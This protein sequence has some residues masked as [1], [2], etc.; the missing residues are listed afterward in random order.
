[1]LIVS[2]AA[3]A[4]AGIAISA[5]IA[6]IISGTRE[7]AAFERGAAQNA[8]QLGIFQEKQSA[9]ANRIQ[10][11][12]AR[13]AS[14]DA[15]IEQERKKTSTLNSQVAALE[16]S[17]QR[18]PQLEKELAAS[19]QELSQKHSEIAR[20]ET[21]VDKERR[22]TEE[23]LA[24]LSEA[25]DQ[26]KTDFQNLANRILEE[27]SAKF[28][29]QNK[30]NLDMVLNPLRDQIGD[31]RKRVDDVYAN[32]SKDRQSLAEKIKTLSDLN[33][34]V[35]K[36]ADNLSKALRGGSGNK[37][38]GN[39]GEMILVRALELSGLKKGIE[40]DTQVS[41]ESAEGEKQIPDV[42]VHLPE[43]RDVVVDSKVTL[44][45]YRK[46]VS[47]ETD[48]E[49]EIALVQNDESVRNHIDLLSAKAYELHSKVKSLDFVL[50]FMPIE[51][52][53]VSA[54]KRD[55]ELF[56]YA[57]GK[58]IILVCPSTLL[59]T[60]RTIQNM[61]QSENQNRHA[62]DIAGRAASLYDKFAGFVETLSEVKSSIAN[63]AQSCDKA[64]S[65]LSTGKGNLI[66]RIEN[67]RTLSV[68]P[69]KALPAAIV[70]A[71]ENTDSLLES[72][73]D[74]NQIKGDA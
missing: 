45:A 72:E 16:I 2:I 61:W 23:K 3:A 47:A 26:M 73:V 32:E 63:A 71:A 62:L 31:F 60:L 67:F 39:W 44:E 40:Y 15:T 6:F 74:Q 59:V 42:V 33:Q 70:E 22:Q 46:S 43:G 9:A 56:E 27:K 64:M 57:Y 19:R 8:N 65:Q 1:M 13:L 50:M 38:Q 53:F 5:I 36:D 35:S 4:S 10:D 17:A 37:T 41:G 69:K 48:E 30:T 12:A 18:V 14:A 20:L 55:P 24:L 58:R 52:A 7:K 34:Q 49:R 21:V 66:H 25:K 54:I 28:T 51:S 68:K 11:L 29:E